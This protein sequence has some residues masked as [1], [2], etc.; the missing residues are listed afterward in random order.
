[1]RLLRFSAIGLTVF[2]LQAAQ[3]AEFPFLD[4]DSKSGSTMTSSSAPKSW[5]TQVGKDW[6]KYLPDDKK[7]ASISIPGTHDT[8]ARHGGAACETQSWSVREQLDAGIRYFDI[9]NRRTKDSFAIHHGPCFQKIMFG[10]VLNQVR[11]FLRSNPS[12]VVLM[13]VKEEHKAEK[14]SDS[15]SKIWGGYMRTYGS[16]FVPQR[17]TLPTLGDVRGKVLVLRNATF[18][19]QGISYSGTNTTIQDS[20]KVYYMAHDNPFGSDTV[21]LPQKKRKVRNYVDKARK[22]SKLVLNHLSGAIGMIP[23]DVARATNGDAYNKLGPYTG[24]K[25]NG[26]MIMDFPGEKLLYRIIKSNFKSTRMCAPKTWKTQSDHTYAKFQ[27]PRASVGTVIKIKGGAYNK[28]VFPKC[29]RAT[30]KDLRF[31]CQANGKWKRMSGSWDADALCHNSNTK[32]KYLK[33]GKR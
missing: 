21:S 23:K 29:N 12:E 1:M 27:M 28:Y 9:R 25:Q 26:V 31:F 14:G 2:S 17:T 19:G 8:G 11:S 3:A 16:M 20:Y 10:D 32:Q 7:L 33:V 5:M 13:R 4:E 15:F 24:R 30:W 22:S 6:M 18:S